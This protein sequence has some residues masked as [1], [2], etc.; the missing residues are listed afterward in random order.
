MK[1]DEEIKTLKKDLVTLKEANESQKSELKDAE[2]KLACASQQQTRLEE[3][4][5]ELESEIKALNTQKL[6]LESDHRQDMKTLQDQLVL[7]NKSNDQLKDSQSSSKIDHETK[8]AEV[9]KLTDR[10][11]AMETEH[12]NEIDKLVADK[13][14]I[15]NELKKEK[16]A[17]SEKIHS[18]NS[19]VKKLGSDFEE[20]KCELQTHIQQKELTKREV[21]SLNDQLKKSEDEVEMMRSQITTLVGELQEEKDRA[22]SST[23]TVEQQKQRYDNHYIDYIQN[24]GHLSVESIGSVGFVNN[25]KS[26]LNILLANFNT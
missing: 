16:Q 1:A 15:E 3:K 19:H 8:E 4:Q 17:N 24:N 7:L 11:T 12:R 9:K 10:L 23:I 20:T 26:E 14:E 6:K 5:C 22:E 18:M 25:K 2:G 21:R 13:K